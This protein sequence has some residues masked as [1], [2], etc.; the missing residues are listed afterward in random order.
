MY[1][2]MSGGKG[3]HTASV[4]GCN[5]HAWSHMGM[6]AALGGQPAPAAAPLLACGVCRTVS[7]G[8]SGRR[9]VLQQQLHAVSTAQ[10]Y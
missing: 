6:D 4:H 1:A 3:G 8:C 5:A 2:L 9:P 10:H 7:A